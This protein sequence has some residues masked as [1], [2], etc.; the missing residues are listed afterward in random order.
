MN[1][2]YVITQALIQCLNN[3]NM[4]NFSYQKH[5]YPF[6]TE[7]IEGYIRF[8][9]LNGKS[10]LTVGS[11]GDQVLNAILFGCQDITVADINIYTRFYYYLKVACILELSIDEYFTFLRFVDCPHY[12][13]WND[14]VFDELVFQRVKDTLKSINYESYMF[15]NELFKNTNSETMRVRLFTMDEYNTKIIKE[16][17]TYLKWE[18]LYLKLKKKIL[19]TNVK[20][21]NTDLLE[22]DSKRKYDNIWLSN[23]GSKLESGYF[24]KLINLMIK[25]L[26]EDGKMLMNY[27]YDTTKMSEY[28]TCWNPI[29]NLNNIFDMFA[30]LNPELYSF[31]GIMDIQK[32]SD[33][34]N[35]SVMIYTK[36]NNDKHNRMC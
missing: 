31:K 6:T 7:N 29:Y 12:L 15:W 17:N 13:S 11:S 34:H 16:C 4:S 26:N 20:F 35:D 24:Y 30:N 14:Q 33:N 3:K 19:L 28:N 5:I 23:I 9:D 21:Q 27:F 36:K 18:Q 25:Y 8:F 22:F 32:N 2:N 1:I 10:L